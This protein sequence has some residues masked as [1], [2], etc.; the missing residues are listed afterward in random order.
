MLGAIGK[1]NGYDIDC[2]VKAYRLKLRP[3]FYY[4]GS[5]P[6]SPTQYSSHFIDW[7]TKE[8]TKNR[9]FFL[10]TRQKVRTI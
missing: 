2:A 10:E 4:K 9:S 5:I 1:I 8:V 3:E 6:G 7:M